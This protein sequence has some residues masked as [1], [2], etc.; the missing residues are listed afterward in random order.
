ME[1]L[2]LIRHI[3]LNV[4]A[5]Q[6]FTHP[7]LERG[8]Y[9]QPFLCRYLVLALHQQNTTALYF[10]PRK[11]SQCDICI[12]TSSTIIRVLPY[13]IHVTWGALWAEM[14]LCYLQ[15][16]LV[17]AVVGNRVKLTTPVLLPQPLIVI[18]VSRTQSALDT[19][20]F[21]GSQ[22]FACPITQNRQVMWS[23][24]IRPMAS[25]ESRG[26]HRLPGE[27]KPFIGSQVTTE[28]A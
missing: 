11:T 14:L 19:I 26:H 5:N 16:K 7:M 3:F 24:G 23:S 15:R 9:D 22:L 13:P 21:D 1:S 2:P 4:Q 10:F 28:K 20:F 12:S 25:P 8:A 6:Y 18:A 17:V 27:F